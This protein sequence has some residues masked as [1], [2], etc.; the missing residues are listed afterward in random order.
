MVEDVAKPML[1]PLSVL[2]L[3]SIL[4]FLNGANDISKGIASL[5]GS[6]VTR[7]RT[8]VLWG[9][10]WTVAGGITAA[11]ATQ[12]LIKAFG[13]N[14]IVTPLPEGYAFLSAI[15]AGTL[16]WI[17][18]ATWTGLPVSTTHAIIGA[19]IGAGL[20]AAGAGGINWGVLLQRFFVPLAVSP[21][22]AFG[23]MVVF[24]RALNN[25]FG[26][27]HRYCVCLHREAIRIATQPPALALSQET[28]VIV[29]ETADCD[30]EP[31]TV[32]SMNAMDALH[33]CSAG[34]TCFARGLNDAPKI[35]AL[36][37]SASLAF[38]LVPAT[39]FIAT[40]I[41]MGLGSLL[42]G[43][44]VTETLAKKLTPM[45]PEEGFVANLITSVLVIFASKLALP[46][47]TTHVST[48]AIIGL[49][50]NR[51][52]QGIHWKTMWHVVFAWLLTLPV[53]AIFAAVVYWLTRLGA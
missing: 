27:L 20:M 44:R 23:L 30:C 19:L 51:S 9:T 12:G 15:A 26:P 11:F 43:L 6:G 46:V 1:A 10:I 40:A 13:G 21:L 36:G 33:W 17:G 47:S 37:L 18:F 2:V 7:A 50:L 3:V 39:G 29:G 48:G 49:G 31:A 22:L 41:A 4:A 28:T 35:F 38:G 14:G 24:G 42:A 16:M 52:P 5:V 32:L 53:A 8:A 45:S 25:C 34:A